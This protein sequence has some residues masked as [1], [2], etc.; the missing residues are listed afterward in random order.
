MQPTHRLQPLSSGSR[1]ARLRLSARVAVGPTAALRQG[2]GRPSAVLYDF[3]PKVTLINRKQLN[4]YEF[5]YTF[6]R[7]DHDASG[8]VR[9]FAY[10]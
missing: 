1:P 5:S 2:C 8:F 4:V 10:N 6:G 3:S 7:I 9:F